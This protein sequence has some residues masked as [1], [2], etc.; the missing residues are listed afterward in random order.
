MSLFAIRKAS[1]SE[2]YFYLRATNGEIIAT[3]ETYKSK[4]GAENGIAAVKREAPG[5]TVIDMTDD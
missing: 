1:N 3:S 5:A 4:Q 2:F